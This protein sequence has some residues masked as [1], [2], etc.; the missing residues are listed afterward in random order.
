MPR[1]P[2]T[3]PPAP[4]AVAVGSPRRGRSRDL[5][6]PPSSLTGQV[7]NS[8]AGEQVHAARRDRDAVRHA[9][10]R[11]VAEA[12]TSA[13]GTFRFVHDAD[14]ADRVHGA[15]RR[16]RPTAM[17]SEAVTV[18]VAPRDRSRR[19]SKMRLAT[20]VL[21]QGDARRSRTPDVGFVQ[22]RTRFGQ[23]VTIKRVVARRRARSRPGRPRRSA[24]GALAHP[25]LMPNQAGAGYLGGVS[26]R[27]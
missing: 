4:P 11:S 26:R 6:R 10:D 17:P 13:D 1:A 3:R 14:G 2:S 8:K 15:G 20:H 24:E 23:W 27:S 21:D 25:V 9:S 22:R 19:S 16:R 12:N 18:A 5:R 7:P